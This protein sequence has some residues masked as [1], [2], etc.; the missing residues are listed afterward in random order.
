M[1]GRRN[2]FNQIAKALLWEVGLVR[3][4]ICNSPPLTTEGSK[5]R[6]SDSGAYGG[7]PP[8]KLKLEQGMRYGLQ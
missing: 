8:Y 2:A 6:L 1:D 4:I 3:P 7:A 5:E